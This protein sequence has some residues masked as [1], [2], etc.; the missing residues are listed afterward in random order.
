[1]ENTLATPAG[2]SRRNLLKA[3]LSAAGGLVIAF[4]M[5]AAAQP[6]S[7]PDRDSGDE[8]TAF[9]VID[10]DNTITIRVPQSEMGQG[11]ATSLA[12][13]LAEELEC[14]WSAV[15]F[16]LASP[17]RNKRERNL[18][19]GMQTVGSGGLRGSARAMQLTGAT[20]RE[21]LR[22][23]AAQT[24]NVAPAECTLESGKCLHRASNRSLEYG[25]LAPLA[26]KIS[27]T[28][29]PVLK[30]PDQYRLAGKW[31]ARLDTPAKLDGS[32]QFGI[33]AKVPGMVYAAVSGSPVRTG[34]VKSV[35][36]SALQGRRGIIA[37]VKLKDAVAVVAD[38]YWRAKSAL[39]ALKIEWD[40]APALKV[41]SAEL[42]KGLYDALDTEMVDYQ[43]TGDV[44]AAYAAPGAR[45]VEAT[46]EAPYLSHSPMEP[47]NCTVRIGPDGVDV[48]VGTQNPM[49]VLDVVAKATGVAPENVYVHNAF[50]GGGFGRRYLTDEVEQ[51]V[52]IAK[53]VGKPV[54]LIWTREQDHIRGRFRP[55][56]VARFKGALDG[57]G[58]AT[59][60]QFQAALPSVTQSVAIYGGS[61]GGGGGPPAGARPGGP[62]GTSPA[63]APPAGA[64]ARPPGGP[65]RDQSVLNGVSGA[66]YA[67]P[68]KLL[69]ATLKTTHIPVTY[70]RAVNASQNGFF[71][72]SFVDEMA[73]AA[74]Q[75]P[76]T[77][78]RSM[79]TNS[80]DWLAVVD[81][82]AEKSGWSRP[83][84]PGR[85]R[86]M[87]VVG[88]FGSI[89]GQ[90]VEVTVA[91]DGKLKVDRVVCVLD[92]RTVINPNTVEQ[93]VESGIIFALSAALYGEITFKDGAVV[94]TNFNS[95]RMVR[96]ADAPPRI[97][98][99]L[100]QSGGPRLGG[101]GESAV[102]PLAPA[103]ANA[104]FA[105]TGKRVRTLPLKNADLKRA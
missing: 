86:G 75:D 17:N 97:E 62:P 79:L 90:V 19:G 85:G 22:L 82:L 9:L 12:M 51:A 61:F 32:A 8:L 13:L 73:H 23:A 6:L 45:L 74:G 84:G 83:L 21:R 68:S 30:T 98:T 64:P 94:E 39:D 72:E 53:V 25:K 29:E 50:L 14:D 81:A 89:C 102:P 26:A 47:P 91:A 96:M 20:A 38:R 27:L 70:W 35:D 69:Q 100:L 66:A 87:A 44:A 59:A 48:W 2:L 18:Y 52:A 10:P 24:W 55:Q 54:K 33:D 41:Q 15:S 43:K 101:V 60:L 5:A 80:P 67:F 104:I 37:V 58:K 95:Y 105:A 40:A 57:D 28:A 88:E 92:P 3:G 36:E 76:Y 93:Q 49:T 11:T 56:A 78:R 46:Y 7:A 65:A 103:L 63:G 1:V 42:R 16:Q 4:P 77:F 71:I 34:T 31:T 99:H